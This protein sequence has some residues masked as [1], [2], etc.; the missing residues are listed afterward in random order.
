MHAFQIPMFGSLANIIQ[1]VK[2]YKPLVWILLGFW[3]LYC[4]LTLTLLFFFYMTPFGEFDKGKTF[5]SH[6][7][8]HLDIFHWLYLFLYKKLSLPVLKGKC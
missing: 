5:S 4:C 3:I 7:I 2:C 8:R 6:N 1:L